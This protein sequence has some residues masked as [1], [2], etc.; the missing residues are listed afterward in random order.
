MND[1]R[2][3]VPSSLSFSF[4]RPLAAHRL[5]FLETPQPPDSLTV[6]FFERVCAF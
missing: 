4:V 6:R 2:G 1:E 5:L 3:V